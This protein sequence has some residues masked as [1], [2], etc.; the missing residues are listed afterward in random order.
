M[1]GTC[2]I[3]RLFWVPAVLLTA[4]CGGPD[5]YIY[6]AGEFNRAS[7]T[8]GKE[9][10]NINTLTICYNKHGTKPEI[11]ASMASSEC[12]K[13]NKRAEFDHQSLTICPLFTPVA[14]IYNCRGG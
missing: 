5:A 2:R 1:L 7:P 4:A 3:L 9:P 13:F 10:R 6:N 14:A 12:A 11:I 8:F